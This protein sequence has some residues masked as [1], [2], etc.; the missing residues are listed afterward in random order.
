MAPRDHLAHTGPNSVSFSELN[1]LATC[2]ER[3]FQNYVQ[4]RQGE[5]TL[6][7]RFGTVM[8]YLVGFWWQTG[9]LMPAHMAAHEEQVT[10]P[11]VGK[12]SLD[13]A[14]WLLDR[15]VE[16]YGEMRA[17]WEVVGTE[18]ELSAGLTLTAGSPR[19]VDVW[20]TPDQ[21]LRHRAS[22]RLIVVERK[23]MADFRRMEIVDVTP[24]ETLYV[25]LAR[26]NGYNVDAVFFDAIRNYRWTRDVHPAADSF[27]HAWLYRDDDQVEGA[28]RWARALLRRRD[29]LYFGAV[30]VD[31]PIK[32]ISQQTCAGCS[33]QDTC[34][35][36]LSFP[37]DIEIED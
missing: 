24:Q 8:H 19:C 7:M 15:Y 36:S 26:E 13:D 22:G 28:L 30:G 27:D 33:Y 9:K 1:T 3:W 34:W 18:L 12:Q 32:N 21:I 29:T 20:G 17:V 5:P 16:R 37:H 10:L 35:E 6:K 2:E 25:W 11:E 31:D 14:D 23:T 4:R